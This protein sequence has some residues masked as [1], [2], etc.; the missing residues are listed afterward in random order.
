MALDRLRGSAGFV[1]GTGLILNGLGNSVLP[2]RGVD[3]AGPGGWIPV[4][5]LLCVMAIVGFVAA[6]LGVLGVSGLSRWVMPLASAA[7]ISALAAHLEQPS[8]D[9]WVGVVL[10]LA[11]PI[12][13]ILHVA[14][15]PAHPRSEYP[16]GWRRLGTAMGFAFLAWVTASAALWPVHRAWGTTQADWIR[17]LPGDRDPRTPQ[18]EILHAVTI[19]APP[20][21]VWPW[22]VQ[23]GQDRAGFYSYDWLER[24]FGADIHNV[25]EVRPDWQSRCVG[26]LVPATQ[27]GYLGGLFGDRPGWVVDVVQPN[28]ALVLR[29]WGA[30]VLTP[31]PGG[32]TRLLVRSTIS[33]DRIPAWAAALNLA[34]FQLPHFIMQRGMLLGIKQRAEA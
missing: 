30:F 31:Q 3:V 28:E 16:G 32:G 14:T 1:L 15:L 18:F 8:S 9:L 26:D 23:I 2:L 19:D 5:T 4:V 33:N 6:G 7:G 17:A 29:D 22:L 27:P 25:D 21:R 11:L 24:L 13:T 34:A 10:S 12:L 20:Q